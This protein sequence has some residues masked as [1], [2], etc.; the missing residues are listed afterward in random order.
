MSCFLF[1]K[2]EKAPHS[3]FLTTNFNIIFV[4]K[5]QTVRENLT[6]RSDVHLRQY[7]RIFAAGLS[8][9]I[10]AVMTPA[11]YLQAALPD[12]FTVTSGEELTL[13]SQYQYISCHRPQQRDS[14]SVY[15]SA[16]PHDSTQLRLFGFIAIKEVELQ[17]CNSQQ[18][19]VGGVPFGIKLCTDGVMV[20]GSGSVQTENGPVNPAKVAGIMEGDRILS[21]NGMT[22]LSNSVIAQLVRQSEGAPLAV[23]FAREE[24]TKTTVVTPALSITDGQ[25]H[26]GLWVRDS[27][28]G[29]GTLTF[30]DPN[31]GSFGGLG[32]AVCDVDT[33]QLM[34]LSQGEMVHASITGLTPGLP[35]EPGELE[36]TF[37]GDTWGSLNK[38]CGSGVYGQLYEEVDFPLMETAH[39]QEI[40]EGPA[41]MLCTISG[42][43]P[44]SYDVEIE[45]IHSYDDEDGRNMVIHITDEELLEQ[46]GGILQG[47]SGS[48]LVQNGK[49]IGAVTHVFIQDPSRGYGIFIDRML[50]EAG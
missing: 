5:T 1:Y 43:E 19:A 10:V 38:N 33:G 14:I 11:L 29:I 49:L 26:I 31:S 23:V 30:Y 48:P 44:C 27:S 7:Y 17:Q 22:A 39:A 45:R 3:S 28:A 32:H 25:W 37:L 40:E 8:A 42:T 9:A 2:F 16:S 18:V 15:G 34:P 20:V 24:T 4:C 47:M 12:R 41:Q 35:G 21:I 6:E 13:S 46:C 50:S 36:G